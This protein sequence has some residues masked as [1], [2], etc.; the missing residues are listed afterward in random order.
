[1]NSHC[2]RGLLAVLLLPALLHAQGTINSNTGSFTL[3]GLPTS[4][5]IDSAEADFVPNGGP[6][7]ATEQWWYFRLQGDTRETPFNASMA[8]FSQSYGGGL[9]TLTF[10]QP[11]VFNGT[12]SYRMPNEVIVIPGASQVIA[13]MRIEN[14][15]GAPLTLSLFHYLDFDVFGAAGD[16]AGMDSPMVLW[17]RDQVVQSH[18]GQYSA[19]N[20]SFF[21]AG[22][23]TVSELGLFDANVDNFAND[24][25]PFGPGDFSGAFQWDVTIPTGEDFTASA[26]FAIIPVPEPSSM[27][28]AGLA[29]GFVA[30]QAWR[31]RRRTPRG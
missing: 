30:W 26:S 8:G 14:V 7:H 25:L 19:T 12:M 13:Y 3:R 16:S 20:A 1:M 17:V 22:A 29:G 28:L 4:P 24:G 5:L 18:F 21:R 10:N 9:A 11:G 2:L 27:A 31:R 23:A 6:D 15:S